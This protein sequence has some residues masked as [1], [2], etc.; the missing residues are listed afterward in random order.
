MKKNRIPQLIFLILPILVLQAC[1][2]DVSEYYADGENPGLAI[3]S[4]NSN[5]VLSCF[6]ADKPWRTTTRT[7]AGLI[8]ARAHYEVYI[9]K[10]I[11]NTLSDTLHI[12]W[13]GYYP[14]N[15]DMPG[16]LTL[17]LAIPKNFTYLSLSALN[18]QRLN[19]DATAGYFSTSIS[20][21][22]NISNRGSGKI[23]FNTALFDSIA[24]NTYNGKLSGLFEANFNSFKITNGRF[25]H[26]FGPDQIRF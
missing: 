14:P 16:N 19:V 1:V 18:G 20:Q 15:K 22:N 21:L 23:Y 12:S 8:F 17:H 6:I 3:F 13:N 7:T 9:Q 5:N 11:T 25:D 4:N 2:K 26:F 10:Q 24:P